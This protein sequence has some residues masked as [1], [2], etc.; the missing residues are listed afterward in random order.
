MMFAALCLYG[1]HDKFGI[2]SNSYMC[3]FVLQDRASGG[4]TSHKADFAHEHEHIADLAQVV[5]TLKPT[6]LIGRLL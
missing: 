4:I 2:V 5:K 3:A 6:A 1:L